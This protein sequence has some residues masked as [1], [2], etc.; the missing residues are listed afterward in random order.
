MINHQMGTLT[1][2]EKQ[3]LEDFGNDPN[4]RI[5]TNSRGQIVATPLTIGKSS[6]QRFIDGEQFTLTWEA[7]AFE[8]IVFRFDEKRCVVVNDSGADKLGVLAVLGTGFL[9]KTG[10]RPTTIMSFNDVNFVSHEGCK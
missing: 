10:N 5:E 6:M 9:Y 3:I 7:S 8:N 1:K 4:Y 2:R